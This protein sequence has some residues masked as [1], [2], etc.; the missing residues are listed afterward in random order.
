L[1]YDCRLSSIK[2]YSEHLF[3][4]KLYDKGNIENN[5]KLLESL[6]NHYNL[7]KGRF[8]GAAAPTTHPHANRK[9]G[10]IGHP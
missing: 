2:K 4:A 9:E 8:V 5:R 1:S 6:E 3:L 10:M 7:P